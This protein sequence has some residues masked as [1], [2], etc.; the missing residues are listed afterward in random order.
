MLNFTFDSI[1]KICLKL[2]H[3][4]DQFNVIIDCA[5]I[6]W[7]NFDKEFEK[8]DEWLLEYFTERVNLVFF[9]NYNKIMNAIMTILW[10]FIPKKTRTKVKM[11]KT[12]ENL[13]E[14]IPAD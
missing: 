11:L 5:N 12:T 14:T 6:G 7:N 4:V 2:P 3:N 8:A 1:R 9:I 13:T 10:P